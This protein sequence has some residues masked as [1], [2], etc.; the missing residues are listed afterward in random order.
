MVRHGSAIPASACLGNSGFAGKSG[1]SGASG[2]P[3]GRPRRSERRFS[4]I[5]GRFSGRFSRFFEVT[6]RERLDSRRDGRNLYFCWQAQ[7]FGGFADFTKKPKIDENCRK[8]APPTLREQ[9]AR[10]KLDFFAPGRDLVSILVA[11]ARSRTLPGAL[12]GVPGRPWRV[13]GRSRGAPRT[14]RDAPETLPRRHRDALGGHGVSREAPGTDFESIL[15]APSRFR[16]R[17]C[18]KFRVDFRV[19]LRT[20]FASE[21]A[22]ER[23]TSRLS[24][25][26][27]KREERCE[28]KSSTTQQQDCQGAFAKQESSTKRESD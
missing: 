17:F 27:G 24:D 16:D 8:I 2:E 10:Q 14:P 22:S 13:S 7:Y 4:T 11:S 26:S 21:L 23:H 1:F 28:A 19:D 18:I 5:S 3:S 9:A 6:S 20:N 25:C 12:S 15:G